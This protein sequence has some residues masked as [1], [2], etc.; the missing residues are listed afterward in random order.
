MLRSVPFDRLRAGFATKHPLLSRRLFAALRVT[1]QAQG[2][3]S[4]RS[5]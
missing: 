1:N 3:S 4:L 5:E 2:D